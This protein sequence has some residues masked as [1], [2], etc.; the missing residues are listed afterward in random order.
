MKYCT[1]MEVSFNSAC[2]LA[3]SLVSP[4]RAIAYVSSDIPAK[5][6][7]IEDALWLMVSRI[8]V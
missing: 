2:D 1:Y 7:S 5:Y 4:G 6:R 3:A 8:G